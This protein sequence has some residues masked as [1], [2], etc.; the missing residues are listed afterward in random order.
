P[1]PYRLARGRRNPI[2]AWLDALDLVGL[3]SHE[4]SVPADVASLPKEQIALFLRH[5][6]AVG[7]SVTVNKN[8]RSG[9]IYYASTS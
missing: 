9:R 7:G 1:A 5:I 8:R 2:A 3:R 6:W 4:K